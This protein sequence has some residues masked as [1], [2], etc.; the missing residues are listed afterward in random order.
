MTHHRTVDEERSQSLARVAMCWMSLLAFAAVSHLRHL[1]GTELFFNGMTTILSYLVFSHLWFEHVRRNPY[2]WPRRRYVS[3]VADLGI[4]TIFLHLGG[5]YVAAFY[6]IFLWIIIG[7][8]IRFGAHFLTWAQ[9]LGA[10]GFGSVL[11]FGAYW[12]ENREV[13]FGLFLGVL[14]LP[15][16]YQTLLRRLHKLQEL[17]VALAKSRLADK[18]KDQFLATMSHE[19]RTPMNGVLGMAQ[20]LETTDLDGEQREHLGIITRSVESLLHIINDILDYSKI[21][22]HGLT[23]EAVPFNLRILLEDVHSLLQS[24]AEAKGLELVFEY[25]AEAEGSFRG[26][27]TRIRQIVFNLVGNA[28]KFT[29]TGSVRM[30]CSVR[31]AKGNADLTMVITDTGIGIPKDRLSA[32]FDQ[33]EQADNSTT[34]QYGG[35]GLGLAISRRLARMMKGDIKVDSEPGKGS[36]FTVTLGLPLCETMEVVE[37]T[38]PATGELPSFGL[39]A[40]VAEDNIF[41]QVVAHNLLQRVGIEIEIAENGTRALEMLDTG[42]YDLVFMDVRMPEMNGIEATTRIRA[43]TDALARIPILAVTADATR[44]DAR[45]CLEAGM[46]LHLSKPLRLADVISAVTTLGLA[47]RQ[48]VLSES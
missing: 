9:I 2:R 18:A 39:R 42:Y 11:V 1:Y 16:F 12:H 29:E 37:P 23:L 44:N 4:M 25:P 8:G 40:L 32:V 41:N 28:I 6:P 10:A 17:E 27:P 36:V 46:D 30:A 21:T 19:I 22:S 33:F 47:S 13:G 5:N 14:V 35:T 20:A 43:R 38:E 24:T 15:A 34:R 3:M 31:P 26:D 48:P 45:K 7:N